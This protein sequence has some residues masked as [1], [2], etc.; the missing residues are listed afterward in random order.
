M[1]SILQ[2]LNSVMNTVTLGTYPV[3]PFLFLG[4]GLVLSSLLIILKHMKRDTPWKGV[5]LRTDQIIRIVSVA[6]LGLLFLLP[7][8]TH[9]TIFNSFAIPQKDLAIFF[10]GNEITSTELAHNHFGK[11]MLSYVLP[12]NEASIV[13]S[14]DTGSA[15]LPY[16]P[17]TLPYGEMLLFLTALL[18]TLYVSLGICKERTKK[19]TLIA[20]VLLCTLISFLVL[21]KSIDGGLF[22]DGAGIAYALYAFLV[23]KKGRIPQYAGP[24]IVIGYVWILVTLYLTG[25]YWPRILFEYTLIHSAIFVVLVSALYYFA[26]GSNRTIQR[27][28]MTVSVAGIVVVAYLQGYS[29]RTYLST[30]LTQHSSYLAAYP[31]EARPELPILG[32]VG[33]LVIYDSTPLAGKTVGQI[34]DTYHLPYWYQPLTVNT[35]QCSNEARRNE[36]R[37]FVLSRNPLHDTTLGNNLA[38]ILLSPSGTAPQGWYRYAGKATQQFCVPRSLDVVREMLR[39][40]G[41]NDFILYG[42]Q[43]YLLLPDPIGQEK[44]PGD[45]IPR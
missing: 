31:S 5:S 42:L 11:T 13:A 7:I 36:E 25:F 41:A 24:Y 32:E 2:I 26:H 6:S 4:Y 43:N 39:L 19:R 10:T 34:I 30:V 44:G 18:T 15:L 14:S 38:D 22:S 9:V 1:A 37:F 17:P 45:S 3:R 28:L 29:D 20:K 21:E 33:T 12:R 40:S 35:K 16:I 23:F 8:I 27:I